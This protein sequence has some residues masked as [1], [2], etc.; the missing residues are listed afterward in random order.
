MNSA[1]QLGRPVE[2][3][4]DQIKTFTEN[5]QRSTMW[6]KADILKIFKSIKLLVTMKHVSFILQNKPHGLFGQPRMSSGALG[7]GVQRGPERE[8]HGAGAVF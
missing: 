4:S 5:N 8:V 2:V 3:D 6:E 1:P 7:S